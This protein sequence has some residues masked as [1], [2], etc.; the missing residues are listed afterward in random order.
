MRIGE[1]SIIIKK[2]TKE[3]VFIKTLILNSSKNMRK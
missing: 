1:D 3:N 2:H